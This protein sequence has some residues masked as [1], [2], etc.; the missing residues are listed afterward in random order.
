MRCHKLSH[1]TIFPFLVAP[2]HIIK[3]HTRI[4]MVQFEIIL[5]QTHKSDHLS[6]YLSDIKIEVEM[7]KVRSW[8][9]KDKE[10]LDKLSKIDDAVS[11]IMNELLE[12]A[13]KQ[14]RFAN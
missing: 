9:N 10:S 13:E 8:R 4:S 6:G 2:F 3:K 1:P 7:M 11:G 5:N 12:L 14:E